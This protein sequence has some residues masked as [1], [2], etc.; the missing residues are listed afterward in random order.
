MVGEWSSVYTAKLFVDPSH[1]LPLPF[2][3]KKKKMKKQNW[4][5]KKGGAMMKNACLDLWHPVVVQ[6]QRGQNIKQLWFKC[7][8]YSSY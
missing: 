1:G 2:A 3:V 5:L 8:E 7:N 6:L 4:Y